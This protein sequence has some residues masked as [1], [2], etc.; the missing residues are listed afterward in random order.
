[1]AKRILFIALL[2]LGLMATPALATDISFLDSAWNP[3]NT[4]SFTRDLGYLGS[5]WAGITL[6]IASGPGNLYWDNNDGNGF[7]DG[8]GVKGGEQD[9][10][11]LSEVLTMTFS[12]AVNLTAI[13]ITDLFYKEGEGYAEVGYYALN[14]GAAVEFLQTDTSQTPS[15]ASNGLLTIDLGLGQSVT[16]ITFTG[17]TDVPSGQNHDY[18][19]SGLRAASTTQ[20]PEP[21]TM[22]LFGTALAGGAFFR[23]RRRS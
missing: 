10:V 7:A 6:T 13:D 3:G 14:G 20:T 23:R 22:L 12:Q 21:G 2:A 1:M 15:P 9:E 18:S 11:D 4:N 5:E 16:S 19:V 17:L 8:Y